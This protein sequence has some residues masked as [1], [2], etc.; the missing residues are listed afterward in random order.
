MN[1]K[2]DGGLVAIVIILILVIFFGWLINLNG[3]ECRSNKDCGNNSY[4]GSDFSCHEFPVIEKNSG[5]GNYVAPAI[6]IGLALV[7]TAIILRWDKIK[8][9]TEPK[10]EEPKEEPVYHNYPLYY[11]EQIKSK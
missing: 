3:R 8:F 9:K 4:C 6:I 11:T 5:N 10:K 7:I 2:G 1:K